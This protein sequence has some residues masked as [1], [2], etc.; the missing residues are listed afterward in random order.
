M[1]RAMGAKGQGKRD[2]ILNAAIRVFAQKG[3]H[4]SRTADIAAEAKVAYGSLYQYFHNKDDILLTI[5]R[6]RWHIL[7]TKFERIIQTSNGPGEEFSRIIDYMFRSYQNNPEMMKVLIMD[8]PRHAQFYSPENWFLYNKFFKMMAEIF[9]KGQETGIFL[10]NV[11]PTIA[12]YAIY[13]AVDTTIRQYVYNPEF[14]ATE[15]PL[16]KA[17]EQIMDILKNGFFVTDSHHGT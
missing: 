14:N 16:Q 2:I 9:E 17:K 13:G 3:Y 15:F 10:K 6:E 1:D 7:L 11:S 5:F 12:S 8:V 4:S